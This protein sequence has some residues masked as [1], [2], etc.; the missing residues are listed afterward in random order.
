MRTRTY[1][2][3]VVCWLLF[4]AG[5]GLVIANSFQPGKMTPRPVPPAIVVGIATHGE[6]DGTGSTIY[7]VWSDGLVEVN[8]TACAGCGWAGWVVVPED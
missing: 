4:T 5:A 1:A 2:F 3:A 8:R 6:F 7:R